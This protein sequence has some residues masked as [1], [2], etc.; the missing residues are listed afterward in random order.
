MGNLKYY[1]NPETCQY[2]RARWKLK[3]VLLYSAGVIAVG[4][5]MFVGIAFVHNRFTESEQEVMLRHENKALKNHKVLVEQKV[6]EVE[7]LLAQLRQKDQDLHSKLF[8]NNSEA[9]AQASSNKQMFLRSNAAGF[10]NLLE[11]TIARS[12]NLISRSSATRSLFGNTITLSKED[13]E[14][15]RFIPTLQPIANPNLDLL[16]S[17]FGTRIN[18]FHKGKH[19]HPGADFAAPR[20]TEVFATASGKIVDVTRSDLEAGYGNYIDIDHGNGFVTR[21]AHLDEITV[22]KGQKVA[23]G[24]VIGT[25][26]NS[27][28]S[29]APHLHYEVI[30]D[31]KN[32]DP[33]IYLI[34]G[35]SPA[36]YKILLSL[37]KMQNQSLD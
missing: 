33:I 31:G 27:G 28:G 14:L 8:E 11:Q 1:Y 12:Q 32:I 9:L 5:F 7:L 10:H 22:S 3:D 23:K 6:S 16:V 24:T 36:Q 4:S 29:V 21:Y 15:F 34:E 30:R 25:V 18:P 17:G 2:E 26:G 19:D 20:G 35:V 37:S 13:V